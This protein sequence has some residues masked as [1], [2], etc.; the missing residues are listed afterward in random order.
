LDVSVWL[1]LFV[2]GIYA[3][4]AAELLWTGK[5]GMAIA[6]A[7]YAAANLGLAMAAR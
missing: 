6:F 1:I 5:Q 2:G 4:I 3:Y 7:G